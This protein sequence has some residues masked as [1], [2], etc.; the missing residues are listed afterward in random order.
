[1][2]NNK[3]I[4]QINLERLFVEKSGKLNYQPDMK[5]ARDKYCE[6]LIKFLSDENFFN[7]PSFE[8]RK[9]TLKKELELLYTIVWYKFFEKYKED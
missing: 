6:E 9:A 5:V 4:K 3:D 7:Q 8:R 2:R 1:M